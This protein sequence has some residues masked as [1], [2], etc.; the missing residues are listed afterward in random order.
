[1]D[2]GYAGAPPAAYARRTLNCAQ[3]GERTLYY[4]GISVTPEC[5][6]RGVGSALVRWVSARADADGVGVGVTTSQD[7]WHVFARNGFDVADTFT[8]DLDK[9]ATKPRIVD[10]KEAK[11]GEYTFRLL[12]RK[13]IKG[14]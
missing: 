11:W 4:F 12:L 2:E 3:L 6:G 8:V 7:G 5:Q 9:Y 13:P 1:V 14:T 10:A